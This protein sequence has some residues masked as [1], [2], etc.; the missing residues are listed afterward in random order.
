MKA[1][2]KYNSRQRNRVKINAWT[3]LVN[4]N[5]TSCWFI[6]LCD[7][8]SRRSY[9]NFLKQITFLVVCKVK[10]GLS[11]QRVFVIY[12]VYDQNRNKPKEVTTC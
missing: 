8:R 4:T 11:Q 12:N 5:I 1:V 9:A 3:R 6:A 7:V 2:C 10:I